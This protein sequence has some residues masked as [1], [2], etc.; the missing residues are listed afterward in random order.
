MLL[1][2]V[3]EVT[4]R[5]I[6]TL[7]FIFKD[8]GIY[9]KIT[10]DPMFFQQTD[11]IKLNYST[12]SFENCVEISPATILFD[13]GIFPYSISE[14][15]FENEFCF[16]FD[17]VVDPFS[18]VFYVLTRMEEYVNN[19]RDEH[20]RFAAKY[21]VLHQYGI[22]QKAMC[23]RWSV[24]IIKYI[25]QKLAISLNPWPIDVNIIPTFD[26][27]NTYAFKWKQNWRHFLSTVKDW[28]KKDNDR[29]KRRNT[30]L[31]GLEKDPYDTFDQMIEISKR[32]FDVHLFWL[33]GDYTKYDKNISSMDQRHKKL[34]YEMSQHVKVGLHP[35]YRSNEANFYLEREKSRIDTILGNEVK[36]SRQHFLKIS[37][38]VTYQNLIKK[39]FTDDFSMGF[40]DEIGFRAGTARPF[41]FFDLS[42]NLVTDYTIHPFAYMDGT[43]HEYKNWSIEESKVEIEK[44]YRE[45]EKFGGDF[46]CIWHNETIGNFSKWKGWTEV[47]DFTLNL[48]KKS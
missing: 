10:N 27:D 29:L 32:G 8:R 17:N 22:L 31:K 45:V 33:L 38:P 12:K 23:D 14:N 20:D 28:I 5:L 40:A 34:I 4:E 21:S 18:S 30:V 44:I 41:K 1:I 24:A 46:I 7:D 25:E 13:T 3:D 15:R 43:I 35:S 37:L 48:S 9:F 36:F 47:L 26:I 16:A 11:E 42:E 19:K 2:Y 39:G 6:Y